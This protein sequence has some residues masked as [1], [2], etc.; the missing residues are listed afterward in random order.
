MGGWFLF[1][2]CTSHY[3]PHTLKPFSALSWTSS[4]P[5]LFTVQKPLLLLRNG[6]QV[7]LSTSHQATTD[8]V[9]TGVKTLELKCHFNPNGQGQDASGYRVALLYRYE[10]SLL[11]NQ[12][13]SLTNPLWTASLSSSGITSGNSTSTSLGGKVNICFFLWCLSHC[14]SFSPNTSL[15]TSILYIRIKN[16]NDS[17]RWCCMTIFNNLL[18]A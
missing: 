10:L 9:I 8:F 4:S 17:Q 13:N 2:S 14:C 7:A 6:H 3:C 5:I 15:L 12:R 1:A 16:P 18:F 11:S